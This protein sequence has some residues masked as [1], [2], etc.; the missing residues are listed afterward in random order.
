MHLEIP[1]FG[2]QKTPIKSGFMR[3]ISFLCSY[4]GGDEENRTLDLT[5]ANRTLSQ[6]SYAPKD[7]LYFIT[8]FKFCTE[9]VYWQNNEF[10][11]YNQYILHNFSQSELNWRGICGQSSKLIAFF[12]VVGNN[13]F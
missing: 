13:D 12:T 7:K 11:F 10:L 6:L 4:Y 8:P 1:A 9:K 2:Q 3:N 5:D